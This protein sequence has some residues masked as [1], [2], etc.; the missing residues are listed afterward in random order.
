MPGYQQPISNQPQQD[1]D[2]EARR[3]SGR[4]VPKP[5]QGQNNMER[6]AKPDEEHKSL[7]DLEP[8]CASVVTKEPCR[9]W[10]L[11]RDDLYWLFGDDKELQ[12]RLLLTVGRVLSRR[13]H[14]VDAPAASGAPR[15]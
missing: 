3:M 4:D 11:N 7:L 14:L 9:L 5:H 15:G 6:G 1:Q 12:L 2:Q 10:E 8:R 13:L